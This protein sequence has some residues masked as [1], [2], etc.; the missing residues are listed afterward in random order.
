MFCL[1]IEK[2]I[3]LLENPLV[4]C[5]GENC[6]ALPESTL[7]QIEVYCLLLYEIPLFFFFFMR[8]LFLY[9]LSSDLFLKA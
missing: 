9:L 5:L 8:C 6:S 2:Y 1:F 7:S 4:N 3:G